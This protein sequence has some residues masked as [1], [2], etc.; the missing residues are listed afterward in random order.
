MPTTDRLITVESAAELLGC[1]VKTIRRYLADANPDRSFPQPTWLP[2]PTGTRPL[3]RLRE[4]EIRR[5]AGLDRNNCAP[6]ILPCSAGSF[7]HRT[8][9]RR[10]RY[11]FARLSTDWSA[12]LA[13][14]TVAAVVQQA[15]QQKYRLLAEPAQGSDGQL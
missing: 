11:D 12:R 8:Q 4:S 9:Q 2:S 3:L 7:F 6:N 5:F 14:R 10:S 15:I 1:S 13:S